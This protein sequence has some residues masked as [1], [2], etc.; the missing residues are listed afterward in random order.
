MTYKIRAGTVGE[1]RMDSGDW[2]F[3]D[4]GFSSKERSCG[5]VEG[6]GNAKTLTF[7]KLVKRVVKEANRR[8]DDPLNLVIEAPLSVAFNE[9]G[10]PTHRSTD[11]KD[12]KMRDWW[13]NAG[14]STMVAAGHLLRKVRARGN[15]EVRLF[16]GFVSFKS[17]D[18]TSSDIEDAQ[19][20][21]DAILCSKERR[22]Y[23]PCEL[24]AEG[25]GD[26]ESAFPDIY[27]GVPPV[28][29]PI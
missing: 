25:S 14:A 20:L 28:I 7:G 19:A 4:I 22:T 10:N 16:E 17:Q 8:T 6:N 5:L 9:K 23:S 18:N 11:R 15:R 1:I 3:I 29:V 26:P 13:Y 21:R 24:K 12:G 2:L 27:C